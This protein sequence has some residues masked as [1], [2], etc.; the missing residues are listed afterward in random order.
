MVPF[1]QEKLSQSWLIILQNL[2]NTASISLN[3][4]VVEASG[5]CWKFSF[6]SLLLKQ[7]THNDPVREKEVEDTFSSCCNVND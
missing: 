4:L 2:L 5:E 6:L 1:H 3:I 7:E